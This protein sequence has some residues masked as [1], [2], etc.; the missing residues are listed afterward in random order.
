M[1]KSTKKSPAVSKSGQDQQKKKPLDLLEK[2]WVQWSLLITISGALAGTFFKIKEGVGRIDSLE[3]S[4]VQI[5]SVVDKETSVRQMM[6]IDSF[7]YRRTPSDRHNDSTLEYKLPPDD[8]LY[9]LPKKL[10]Q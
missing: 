3:K 5:K 8:Y 9:Y 1:G 4:T 10:N 7:Y 2:A 6:L